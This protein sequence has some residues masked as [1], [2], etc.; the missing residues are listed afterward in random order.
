MCCFFYVQEYDY[1]FSVDIEEGKPPLKLPYNIAEDPWF[2]AQNF[3]SKNNL[4]Q[5]FLDQVANFILDNTKGVTLNQGSGSGA[6]YTDP[7]T[8]H[9]FLL[10]FHKKI[11]TAAYVI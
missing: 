3:L 1:V 4:S 8:G 11:C 2:A 7:F 9:S 5:L 10:I 6:G